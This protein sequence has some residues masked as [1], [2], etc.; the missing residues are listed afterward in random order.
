M[1]W[2]L[3]SSFKCILTAER[4]AN[5]TDVKLLSSKNFELLAPKARLG[6]FEWASVHHHSLRGCWPVNVGGLEKYLIWPRVSLDVLSKFWFCPGKNFFRSLTLTS[7]SFAAPL[8][9]IMHTTF[10]ES[11]KPYP[12]SHYLKTGIEAL[13]RYVIL[14][15]S[16]PFYVVLI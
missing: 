9:M 13:L 4:A 15:Q 8:P 2:S 14:T 11:S 12:F 5:L 10:F 6:A 7:R 1:Q 3:I 16:K